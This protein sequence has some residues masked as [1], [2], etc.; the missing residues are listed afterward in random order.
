MS[1]PSLLNRRRPTFFCPTLAL[2]KRDFRCGR[3]SELGGIFEMRSSLWTAIDIERRQHHTTKNLLFVTCALSLRLNF[4]LNS[5]SK[6]MPAHV[7]IYTP[8]CLDL[9][10]DTVR[11][12]ILIQ[13]LLYWILLFNNCSGGACGFS[14]GH[15][16]PVFYQRHNSY[17]IRP[18]LANLFFM[19]LL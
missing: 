16:S 10:M 5:G 6:S 9:Q 19:R 8:E 1:K 7:P 4:C 11:L 2:T 18:T 14:F 17:L 13:M 15:R 12:L 3:R